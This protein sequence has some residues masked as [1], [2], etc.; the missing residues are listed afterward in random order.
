MGNAVNITVELTLVTAGH[1]LLSGGA[2]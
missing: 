1:W 2:V